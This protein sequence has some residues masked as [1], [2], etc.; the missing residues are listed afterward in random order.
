M[1]VWLAVGFQVVM[2]QPRLPRRFLG[3]FSTSQPP[4]RQVLD[5]APLPASRK[6]SIDSGLLVSGSHFG[7]GSRWVIF[8]LV[9]IAALVI[10]GCH[11]AG[12]DILAKFSRL[13]RAN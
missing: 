9:F 3:P 1:A 4:T 13:A 2:L 5:M 11:T 6:V 12:S 10:V 7:L 8:V